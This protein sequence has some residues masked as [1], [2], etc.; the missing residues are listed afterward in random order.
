M[1]NRGEISMYHI[2]ISSERS[3]LAYSSAPGV[4][5]HVFPVQLLVLLLESRQPP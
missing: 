5:I 1:E 3:Y 4:D 2:Q